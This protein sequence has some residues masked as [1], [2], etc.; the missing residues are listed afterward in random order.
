M[1][2][3]A[4][5]A[6]HRILFR[7]GLKEPLVHRANLYGMIGTLALAISMTA[8]TLMVVDYL[9]AGPLPL[10]TAAGTAGVA[11]WLWFIEPIILRAKNN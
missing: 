8:A 1:F 6:Q 7:Q 10:I 3:I 4:P 11:A 5:V 2:F 9:F